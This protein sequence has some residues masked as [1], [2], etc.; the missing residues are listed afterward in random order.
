MPTGMQKN[1]AR[2][3]VRTKPS[4]LERWLKQ[5]KSEDPN[6]VYKNE[7]NEEKMPKLGTFITKGTDHQPRV[8]TLFPEKC[9]CYIKSC[10][11]ILA[12][13]KSLGMEGNEKTT[14]KLSALR[15]ADKKRKAGRIRP[16]PGDFDYILE[17]DKQSNMVTEEPT[18][19][20]Y[21]FSEKFV[22]MRRKPVTDETSRKPVTDETLRKPVTD[23][24]SRKPLTGETSRKPVTGDNVSEDTIGKPVTTTHDP[25]GPDWLQIGSITLKDE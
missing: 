9:S 21:K 25:A 8:V 1:T 13:K 3:F 20:S 11:H 6:A 24:T 14:P 23:E 15:A 16:R 17:E 10:Y 19:M 22:T 7:I 12:V 2:T 18:K 5:T 4:S